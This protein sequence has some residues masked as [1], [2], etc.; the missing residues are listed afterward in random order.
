MVAEA[1]SMCVLPSHLLLSLTNIKAVV[2]QA[3]IMKSEEASDKVHELQD[4]IDA[5]VNGDPGTQVLQKLALLCMENPVTEPP[6]PPPSPGLELPTSPSPFTPPS[7][8]LPSLH[9][10]L[11]GINKNFDRLFNALMQFLDHAKVIAYYLIDETKHSSY[12]SLAERRRA[13]IRSN[14]HLGNAGE[15]SP[16]SRRQGG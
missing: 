2:G 7:G 14:Y 8:S 9:G 1:T 6:S 4:Y 10:N 16:L 5:V 15:P 3:T 11:W 12:S 13:R